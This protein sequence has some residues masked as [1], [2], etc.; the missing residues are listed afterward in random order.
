MLR[1]QS[2]D[3]GDYEGVISAKKEDRSLSSEINTAGRNT[4]YNSVDHH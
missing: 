1:M 2:P 4:M 3:P